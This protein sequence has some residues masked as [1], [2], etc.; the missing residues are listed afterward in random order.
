MSRMSN[1]SAGSDVIIVKPKDNIYTVLL[2]VATIAQA[3]AFLIVYL[4]Y[5][6]VFG[7]NIFTAQ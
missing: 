6:T 5:G 1:A 2:I 7:G 4:Q 3:L